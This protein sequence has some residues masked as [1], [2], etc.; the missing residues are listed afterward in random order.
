MQTKVFVVS[1]SLALMVPGYKKAIEADG[2]E[3][4]LLHRRCQWVA[5]DVPTVFPE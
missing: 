5:L 3:A 2:R 4:E 1:Q